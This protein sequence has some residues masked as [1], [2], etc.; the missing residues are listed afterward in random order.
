MFLLDNKV[1]YFDE[2]C[3]LYHEGDEHELK[4]EIMKSI[5]TDLIEWSGWDFAF[6]VLEE[7]IEQVL[8][9][10]LIFL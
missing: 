4:C 9:L 5:E 3:F 10:F 7:Q 1:E 8:K 2:L 6:L